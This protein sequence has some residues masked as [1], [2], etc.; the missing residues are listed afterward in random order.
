MQKNY[1]TY[2][3]LNLYLKVGYAEV[4]EKIKLI[5]IISAGHSGSTLLDHLLSSHSKVESGGELYKYLPYVSDTLG[6]RPDSNRFCGC[7]D[8]INDCSYWEKVKSDIKNEYNTFEV[9][10]TSTT[11]DTFSLHNKS[12]ITAMLKASQKIVFC[13][14]SKMIG[15]MEHFLQSDLFDVVVVHIIRD[16]RAVGYSY[17]KK[18]YNYLRT[19]YRWKKL[20]KQHLVSIKC[21]G[22]MGR[23]ISL[24][25]EDLVESPERHLTEILEFVGL[26]YEP[27]QL[28]FRDG[29]HHI[30]SGNRMRWDSNQK[31]RRDSTYLKKLNPLKWIGAN[32]IAGVS[33]LQ[34][35]YS[36]FRARS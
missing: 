34:S 1:R 25:Y 18:G 13:D 33:L 12:V 26:K 7:G 31:I 19:I 3:F 11:L 30:L 15:R 17:Q 32:I 28:N 6:V 5:Y 16:A 20:L 27:M 9:D 2:Y 22:H 23:V 35:G 36:L 21:Y 14:S 24:R 29:E 10:L 8:H 4:K